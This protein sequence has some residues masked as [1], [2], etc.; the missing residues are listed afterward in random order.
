MR[1][2]Y[3]K[4]GTM[5][6]SFFWCHTM[7]RFYF[8]HKR[9]SK[10]MYFSRCLQGDS[11]VE[12]KITSQHLAKNDS[13]RKWTSWRGKDFSGHGRGKAGRGGENPSEKE[14]QNTSNTIGS[15]MAFVT[16][17]RCIELFADTGSRGSFFNKKWNISWRV[18]KE[19]LGK[20]L[21]SLY[22]P[23]LCLQ[24]ASSIL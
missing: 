21:N 12:T 14:V 23:W 5:C 17:L 6:A 11:P 2:F 15:L 8:R 13:R 19:V 10:I 3:L 24:F 7:I 4:E 18:S 1:F 22:S 9:F 16:K 20:L